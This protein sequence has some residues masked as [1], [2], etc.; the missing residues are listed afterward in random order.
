MS[1]AVA[2]PAS[3]A[4]CTAARVPLR[5][6]ALRAAAAL[7]EAERPSAVPLRSVDVPLEVERAAAVGWV[8]VRA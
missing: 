1:R 4:A 2:S 5:E 7:R 3:G 6:G 8:G